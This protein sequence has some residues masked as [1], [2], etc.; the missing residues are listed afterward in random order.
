MVVLVL[1]VV[2]VLPRVAALVMF[3]VVLAVV[4][5]VVLVMLLVVLVMLV[6]KAL[7]VQTMLVL[8][9][10]VLKTVLALPAQTTAAAVPETAAGAAALP[11]LTPPWWEFRARAVGPEADRH[12]TTPQPREPLLR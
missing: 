7:V 9:V 10:L 12:P 11:W 4:V 5:L 8:L 2:L 6:L 3:G 1:R